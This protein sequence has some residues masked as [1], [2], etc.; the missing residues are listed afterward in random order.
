MF[1]RNSLEP[2]VAYAITI[3]GDSLV[4]EKKNIERK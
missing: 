3:K 1:A 4:S 2:K